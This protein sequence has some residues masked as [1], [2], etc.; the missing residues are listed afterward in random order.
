MANTNEIRHH[1]SAVEQ[2]SK[3]TGAMEMVSSNR[4]RRVMSHIDYNREYFEHIRRAMREIL[5][6]AEG[7]TNPYL[8][9]RPEG[10]RTYVVFTSDKGLCGS[11]NSAVL[12]LAEQCLA[13]YPGSSVITVGNIGEEYFRRAGRPADISLL[14]IVQDPT[15]KTARRMSQ[16]ILELYD[17]KFTDEL[18]FIYT[19]FY[20]ETKSQ[21]V[22]LRMLPIVR[23]DYE[24][25]ESLHNDSSIIYHPSPEAVFDELVPQ[26]ILGLT[27]GIM[28]QAYAS[29]H[30]ARMNAMHA[31]TQN[32]ND[33]LKGLRTQYNLARQAAITNELSEITGAAEI[34]RGSV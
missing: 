19:S 33:M 30:Y 25:V 21:P 3:I 18:H 10:R 6:A 26:Y 32:A 13:E 1:I 20:G 12:E 31:S 15:M 11:Y 2:T 5:S 29:E 14:G 28:V 22:E 23:E 17:N 7:L 34:L 24:D 9:T 4:M 16:D 8:T 27:F